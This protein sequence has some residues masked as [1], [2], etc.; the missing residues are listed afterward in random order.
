MVFVVLGELVGASFF[1]D[2]RARILI[3]FKFIYCG[4]LF[5]LYLF[6]DLSSF[7]P[8]FLLIIIRF[9]LYIYYNGGGGTGG[10]DGAYS[11]GKE[12]VL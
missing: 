7:N 10:E 6:I 5:F 1:V 9:A 8:S 2:V 12:G 11:S 3:S 4:M